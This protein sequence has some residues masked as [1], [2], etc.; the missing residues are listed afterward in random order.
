[1]KNV[2]F[3]YTGTKPILLNFNYD[4]NLCLTKGRVYNSNEHPVT[5][6][7]KYLEVVLKKPYVEIVEEI[8]PLIIEEIKPLI[9]E[10]EIK[11]D[12]QVLKEITPVLKEIEKQK[13]MKKQGKKKWK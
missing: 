12:R 5:K 6:N 8:K 1:M 2:K 11:T 7:P 4:G 3:K 13:V 10:P 9:I